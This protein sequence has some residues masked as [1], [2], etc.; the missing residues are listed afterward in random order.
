MN[1][2]AAFSLLDRQRQRFICGLLIVVAT[3]FHYGAAPAFAAG[4]LDASFDID[5]IRVITRPGDDRGQ[6][7]AVQPIDGKIVVGGYTDRFGLNDFLVMRF[8]GNGVLDTTFD[9]DGIRVVGPSGENLANALALQTDQ[10]IV[11]VGNTDT[12]DSNDFEVMR[13]LGQ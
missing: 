5:G 8:S 1:P 3:F 9:I 13:F 7:V 11:L 2:Y 10:K 12:F 6:A 4:A